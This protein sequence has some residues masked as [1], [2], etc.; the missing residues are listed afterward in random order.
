MGGI[1]DLHILF[2]ELF[3]HYGSYSSIV[4]T[5]FVLNI[6]L[7]NVPL[8]LFDQVRSGIGNVFNRKFSI[9]VQASEY[10]L[11]SNK[12]IFNV[13]AALFTENSF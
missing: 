3:I 2:L 6:E 1:N 12:L 7:Q 4:E 8:A 5:V 11:K 10:E 9:I 13:T